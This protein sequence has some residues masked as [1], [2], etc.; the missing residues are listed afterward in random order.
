MLDAPA[1][2]VHNGCLE[3]ALRSFR[4]RTYQYGSHQVRFTR[5]GLGH[6]LRRHHPRYW[7]G[8]VETTQSY[9][10]RAT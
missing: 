6:M 10:P 7:D 9:F 5:S 8:S 2:W 3:E 4:P 1:V